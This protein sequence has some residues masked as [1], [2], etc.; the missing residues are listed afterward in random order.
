MSPFKISFVATSKEF[1]ASIAKQKAEGVLFA[2]VSAL[3]A[4]LNRI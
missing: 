4:L 2:A 3:S 1:E